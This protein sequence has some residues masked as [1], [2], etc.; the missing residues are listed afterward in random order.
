MSKAQAVVA[1]P[2]QAT[3]ADVP[4]KAGDADGGDGDDSHADQ[5]APAAPTRLDHARYLRCLWRVVETARWA[6]AA[7]AAPPEQCAP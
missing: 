2:A 1:A 5:C 7:V 4:E 3:V 6:A